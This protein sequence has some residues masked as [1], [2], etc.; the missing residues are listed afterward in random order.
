MKEEEKVKIDFYSYRVELLFVSKAYWLS[1]TETLPN[2]LR[3]K[4]PHKQIEKAP[5][6][7]AIIWW[8]KHFHSVLNDSLG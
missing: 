4:K 8:L 3:E 7:K 6:D 5:R 1:Q 2:E